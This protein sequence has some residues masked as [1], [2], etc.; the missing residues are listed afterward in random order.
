MADAV[1]RGEK[2][3]LLE[4]VRVTSHGGAHKPRNCRSE[5]QWQRITNDATTCHRRL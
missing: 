1:A 2:H 4:L 3:L 5:E